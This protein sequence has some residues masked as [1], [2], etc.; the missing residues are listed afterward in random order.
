MHKFFIVFLLLVITTAHAQ[1]TKKTLS[2]LIKT[3]NQQQLPGSSVI[4]KDGRDKLIAGKMV[5]SSGKVSFL[6]DSREPL[7]ILVTHVGYIPLKKALP[8]AGKDTTLVIT[9]EADSKQLN[10]VT[11]TG[12]KPVIVMEADRY[13]I[14]VDGK[15][16][17]GNSVIDILK[18]SPGITIS[19]DQVLLEGRAVFLQVNGK[20]VPL[21][22]KELV[23]YLSSSSSTGI[24]QVEL[25][26]TP[27]SSHD[28]SLAGG[29]INL[30]LKKLNKDGYNGNL[31]VTAGY[32]STY[33]Y[34]NVN[35][36]LN[37]RRGRVNFFGS[38]GQ[39]TGKQVNQSET[40]RFF[41]SA[42][43]DWAVLEENNG[44]N[45]ST[46]ISYNAG[47][48]YY[49]N[50]KNTVGLL[51]NG[52][53]NQVTGVLNNTSGIFN[54]G[55]QDSLNTMLFNTKRK[56]S[57]A[58]IDLSLK[59]LVDSLGQEFNIDLD[60][61]FIKNRNNG[62]QLY[63]YYLPNGSMY[64]NPYSV[65]QATDNPFKL[66][67][68]K[69]DYTKPFKKRKLETGVKFT[70]SKINYLMNEE[71]QVLNNGS[72]PIVLPD[73]FDYRE[74]I[75]AAYCMMSE[76]I[77]SFSYQAGIRGEL[78]SID[79]ISFS[80]NRSF[81]N[82]YF[83]VFPTISLSKNITAKSNLSLSYRK[84]IT[85]PRFNQLNPFRYNLSPF[86][87]YT[88]N[89]DLK[90]YYPSTIRAGFSFNNKI[91]AALSYTYTKDK[92]LEYSVQDNSTRITKGIKEN[93]GIYHDIYFSSSYYNKITRWWYTNTSLNASYNAY[94]FVINNSSIKRTN[95]SFSAYSTQK[96][97]ISKTLLAELYAY[98]SSAAY[99][100][101]VYYKPFWYMDI[102]I[103]KD[104]L[105]GKGQV[106]FNVRD[107]FYTNITRY[108][109]IYE[110]VNY[111]LKNRWDSRKFYL[112]A[113]YRFGNKDIKS[114]RSGNNTANDD[115]K[116]RAN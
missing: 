17:I 68:A 82:S 60:Y 10:T 105:A 45:Q 28:A 63:N 76:K 75:Y 110:N 47:A 91:Q 51:V 53:T 79:G 67:G 114:R 55:I 69:V 73:T 4:L 112:S 74:N 48:D 11:V 101:A 77:K 88:G 83:N 1:D 94:S 22:G 18:K 81:S 49:I 103:Y 7:Y 23:A 39:Y 89:P 9:L 30:K 29:V 108:N 50:K 109:A 107:L 64:S 58:T 12:E 111:S 62:D 15:T 36:N 3:G 43:G 56:E 37:A 98:Y 24:S 40:N 80:E 115:I 35:L 96:L 116:S 113:S 27:S 32:R 57:L 31:S 52:Y 78:T 13:T 38:I 92:I 8:P 85:R 86:F 20:N 19:D 66:L 14:N 46:G 54:K 5:D 42:G 100:G 72:Q 95:R 104:I 59:S 97:T 102:S 25:I 16:S 34:D 71:R 70:H 26:T 93:N 90:P 21:A 65:D 99:Y 84:S 106:S 44:I 61:D 2:L 41:N 87:Y 6:L 33:P